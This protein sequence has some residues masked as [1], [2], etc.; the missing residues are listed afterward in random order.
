MSA[1]SLPIRIVFAVFSRNLYES[2]AVAWDWGY[3]LRVGSPFA[4]PLALSLLILLVPDPHP[5][6]AFRNPLPCLVDGLPHSVLDNQ[7]APRHCTGSHYL[8]TVV[9]DS[10]SQVLLSADRS[11][12]MQLTRYGGAP[13]LSV[14]VTPSI[15]TGNVSWP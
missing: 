2:C 5:G 1:M 9:M 13:T 7:H 10:Y 11:Q 3:P 15:S 12:N 6:E 4:A 14:E 8:V